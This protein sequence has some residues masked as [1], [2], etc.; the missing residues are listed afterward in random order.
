MPGAVGPLTP[1]RPALAAR[2][3]RCGRVALRGCAA[4]RAGRPPRPERGG[5]GRRALSPS[6]P[7][8]R[9]AACTGVSVGR[10]HKTPPVRAHPP[11]AS[12]SGGLVRAACP[13]H[14]KTKTPRKGAKATATAT[15]KARLTVAPVPGPGLRAARCEARK[16]ALVASL[17][18]PQTPCFPALRLC[19]GGSR[20][21]AKRR[22]RKRG[23]T[24][25]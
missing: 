16:P 15:A 10:G 21:A 13:A 19:S 4:R 12:R 6:P 24:R 25:P 7:H 22:P 8:G 9:Y 17:A 2:W 18:P 5:V 14:Q 3:R 20:P 23:A 11:P 1:L